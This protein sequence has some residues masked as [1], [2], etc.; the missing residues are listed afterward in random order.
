MDETCPWDVMNMSLGRRS[1][2]YFVHAVPSFS[3]QS[4]L[5]HCAVIM[6]HTM[7]KEWWGS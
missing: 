5:D 2:C 6:T 3:R 4:P 7:V 1:F